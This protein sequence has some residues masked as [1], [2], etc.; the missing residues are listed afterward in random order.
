MNAAISSALIAA[1]VAAALTTFV[2]RFFSNRAQRNQV[3]E[4]TM[5]LGFEIPSEREMVRFDDLLVIVERSVRDLRSENLQSE[6]AQFR[7]QS[8][9][10]ALPVAVMVFDRE[11]AVV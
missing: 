4:S 9:L 7:L 1:V 8:A 6:S 11:G 3:Y 2:A 5:R 10:N